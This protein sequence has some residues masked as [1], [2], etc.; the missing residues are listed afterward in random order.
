MSY[1]DPDE[2]VYKTI[3]TPEVR[4]AVSG[5]AEPLTSDV[6]EN[7]ESFETTTPGGVRQ[8][9]EAPTELALN[10]I[11]VTKSPAFWSLWVL[12]LALVAGQLSLNA[13]KEKRQKNEHSRRASKATKEA[14][15]ELGRARKNADTFPGSAGSILRN[16]LTTRLDQPIVGQ[17]Y[18]QLRVTLSG[19]GVPP[20]LAGHV[21]RVFQSLERFAYKPDE[22]AIDQEVIF[23][24][25]NEV[26]SDLERTFNKEK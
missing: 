7:I 26:I 1:F 16:Y 11:D 10:P 2:Q 15:R 20:S 23:K 3:S 24:R 19:Q 8:L 13:Y 14:K 25:V 17:T 5:A 9:K 4:I 22:E 12:P 6:P 18:P 21:I